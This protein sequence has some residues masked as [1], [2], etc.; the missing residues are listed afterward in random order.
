MSRITNENVYVKG[1]QLGIITNIYQKTNKALTNHSKATL[2]AIFSCLSENFNFDFS[3]MI[4][5]FFHAAENM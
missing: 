2:K 3:L 4:D 1:K 5:F